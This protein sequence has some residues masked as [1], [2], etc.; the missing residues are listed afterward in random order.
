MTDLICRNTMT[1]CQTPGMCAPHGGCKVSILVNAN[2]RYS[3]STAPL[4]T[5]DTIELFPGVQF[6]KDMSKPMGNQWLFLHEGHWLISKLAYCDDISMDHLAKVTRE[7]D[8]LAPDA[9]RYR[10]LR[11]DNAYFPEEN[12][13]RGGS[14]LDAAI[15][16]AMAPATVA[17]I[18]PAPPG[19]PVP[20]TD[21][22]CHE[23]DCWYCDGTGWQNGHRCEGDDFPF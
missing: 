8:A 6:R 18:E 5:P 9:E 3:N 1:R 17:T 13:L 14:E 7:R 16:A 22:I 10:W 12:F 19:P 15:D 21:R 20:F 4:T 11:D 2:V 23:P